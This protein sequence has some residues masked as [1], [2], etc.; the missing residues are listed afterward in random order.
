MKKLLCAL[1]AAALVGFGVQAAV[2]GERPIRNGVG[3]SSEGVIGSADVPGTSDGL[4]DF[5]DV[6][7]PCRFD[8]TTALRNYHGVRFTGASP[9]N[10]GAILDECANFGVT[11]YSPP[12]FLAFNCGTTLR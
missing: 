2:A 10:G 9:D 6:T 4:I 1:G 12:N 11:G 3:Q 7:A 5:D 8:H